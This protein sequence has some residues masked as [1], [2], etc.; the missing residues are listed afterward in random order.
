MSRASSKRSS[1]NPSSKSKLI[2]AQSSV[3]LSF[4]YRKVENTLACI[5]IESEMINLS[6]PIIHKSKINGFINDTIQF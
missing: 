1:M 5:N 3:D 4:V 6:K 2:K